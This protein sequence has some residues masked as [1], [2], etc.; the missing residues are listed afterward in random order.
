MCE[1]WIKIFFKRMFPSKKKVF[2][3]CLIFTLYVLLSLQ[4][5][6]KEEKESEKERKTNEK[7]RKQ[8]S[9]K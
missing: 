1:V 6:L 8:E 4:F 9:R 7:A 2:V 5:H 3:Y